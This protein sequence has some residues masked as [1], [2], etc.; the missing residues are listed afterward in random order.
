MR[1]YEKNS[2]SLAAAEWR[3][4]EKKEEKKIYSFYHPRVYFLNSHFDRSTPSHNNN[5]ARFIPTAARNII[6]IFENARS[7]VKLV[8][9][10]DRYI[11]TLQT[12]FAQDTYIIIM[13]R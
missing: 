13:S 7:F 2:R 3:E 4:R 1:A 12:Y 5:N 10:N 11:I 6:I 8:F 9:V